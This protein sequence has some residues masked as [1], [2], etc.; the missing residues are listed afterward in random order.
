MFKQSLKM[1]WESI[2]SNKMRSFLTMLGI[3]IGVFAL[4][5]LV[6][7][8]NGATSSITDSIN[9]L[10]S[11]SI[12]VTVVDDKEN[13]LDL[14][15]LRALAEDETI[16]AVSPTAQSS[17][18]GKSAYNSESVTVYGVTPEYEN[19]GQLEMAQGRFLKTP[20]I[21]NHSSSVIVSM[22]VVNDI[23][24]FSSASKAIGAE[25]MLNGKAYQIVGVLAEEEEDSGSIFGGSSY[26]AYIPYT[27]LIRL[28][29]NISHVTSFAVSSAI[30]DLDTTGDAVSKQLLKRFDNDED[31]FTILNISSIADV[32]DSVMGTMSLLLG[33]IAAI[34]LLVGGI[35]I[36]N[37]MLVSVTERTKEI[38][39]RKAIGAGRSVIMQQFLIEALML[40]LLGS[41]IGVVM[42]WAA[43]KIISLISGDI[44][45]YNLSGGVVVIAV[46]FSIGIGLLFGLYPAN[47]AAK[48]KPIDALRYNG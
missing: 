46:G 28:V 40:S 13:P 31:A 39:I 5:V 37:I 24:S 17:V 2:R 25:I 9:S 7:I 4:V 23:L 3:I 21:D 47:N 48:K 43:L 20:D 26:E 27:S 45:A 42:S 34:S 22:D 8:V 44:S 41:A 32:M 15:D 35:G 16:Q 12:T 30:E 6:S 36:M 1:A 33:G 11:N 14:E 29:D 38:G 10:G 18:T 19:I